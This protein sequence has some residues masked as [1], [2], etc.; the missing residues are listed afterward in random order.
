MSRR[1]RK[2]SSFFMACLKVR[3]KSS[4][5]DIVLSMLE[6]INWLTYDYLT[7][8]VELH[9]QSHLHSVPASS[10]RAFLKKEALFYGQTSPET[11]PSLSFLAHQNK[12]RPIL[13]ALHPFLYFVPD[14]SW[15]DPHLR[16]ISVNNLCSVQKTDKNR[17]L[18]TF[19]DG[20]SLEMEDGQRLMNILHRALSASNYIFSSQSSQ[21]ASCI[22]RS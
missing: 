22:E 13:I 15:K 2:L 20:E 6:T 1:K 4:G 3:P 14:R 8:Q 19:R 10:L 5:S 18:L 9:S 21:Y 11:R 12:F 7:S 17:C 16:L